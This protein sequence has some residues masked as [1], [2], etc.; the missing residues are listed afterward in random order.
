MA[1]A[2]AHRRREVW[3]VGPLLA[4]PLLGLVADR[5]YWGVLVVPTA[6]ALAAEAVTV[7]LDRGRGAHDDRSGE[8]PAHGTAT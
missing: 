8:A 5:P 1:L 3:L 4:L 2:W 6:L 7:A